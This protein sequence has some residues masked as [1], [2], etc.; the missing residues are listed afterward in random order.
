MIVARARRLAGY[1]AGMVTDARP[2]G[3][4]ER[5]LLLLLLAATL[6]VYLPVARHEFIAFDDPGYLFENPRV[7]SG[8][9]L[10]GIAW[11][12]TTGAQS[13]WTP[14]TWISHMAAA[15]VFGV[16]GTTLGLPASG[17]HH[18]V[19]LALHPANTLLLCFL[20]RR[21][22]GAAGASLLVAAL[23]A[24]HPLHVEAVAWVSARKDTLSTLF[25]FAC[26]LAYVEWTRRRGSLRYAVVLLL[27]GIGLLCK[28]M[29]VTWP[30]VMLLLDLWPL[31]RRAGARLLLIEKLPLFALVAAASVVTWRFEE[32]ALHLTRVVPLDFRVRNAVVSALDYLRQTLWPSGLAVLYPYPKE[33][34]AARVALAA[35]VVALATAA[36]LVAARRRPWLPVGWFW[37]VG[38]LVPVIG[39]LQFGLHARADRFTYVPLAGLFIAF[40]WGGAEILE[41]RPS[42]RR[43]LQAAAIAILVALAAVSARQVSFWSDTVTLFRH[44]CD[45]TENNGWGHRILG[46][47]LL[48]RGHPEPAIGE[49]ELALRVWPTDPEALNNLGCALERVGRLEEAQA[50]LAAA[51]RVD[52]TLPAPRRNLERVR[53]ELRAKGGTASDR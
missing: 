35:L 11:A 13:G 15:E 30:C 33:L 27:L 18:L 51:V 50:R 49:L 37:F 7:R 3:R 6:V 42:L 16:E 24:L 38:T 5:F 52:P 2:K 21:A 43:P 48:E 23:F 36:A 29:L 12:F 20:L 31:R 34:A 17:W 28:P 41:S 32:P 44:A 8:V 9:T 53:R 14:L 4:R 39:I 26:L 46:T 47:A 10:D 19:D 45:A 40:A 25:G 22:T 1:A